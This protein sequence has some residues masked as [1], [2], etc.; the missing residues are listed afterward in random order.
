MRCLV[1]RRDVSLRRSVQFTLLPASIKP[2]DD[3]ITRRPWKLLCIG[4]RRRLA[5]VSSNKSPLRHEW[6]LRSDEIKGK[7]RVGRSRIEWRR[8]PFLKRGVE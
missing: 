1:V 4:A 7:E 5:D 3:R 8:A 6:S 2:D